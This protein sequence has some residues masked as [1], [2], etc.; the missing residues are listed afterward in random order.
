MKNCCNATQK[1]V[2]D[3]SMGPCLATV[4]ALRLANLPQDLEESHP[5]LSLLD[6]WNTGTVLS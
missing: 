6:Y 5:L 2:T 4:P 1:T 3:C